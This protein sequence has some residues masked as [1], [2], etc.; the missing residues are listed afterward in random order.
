MKA[1]G[2]IDRLRKENGVDFRTAYRSFPSRERLHPYQKLQTAYICM[3]C[4]YCFE[5]IDR[6]VIPD[7]LQMWKIRI[8]AVG[9]FDSVP[10]PDDKKMRKV[11]SRA[12]GTSLL[13]RIYAIHEQLKA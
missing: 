8:A 12:D 5:N 10:I 7:L 4:L 13:E 6:S 11:L 9:L 3:D 1:V 2:E